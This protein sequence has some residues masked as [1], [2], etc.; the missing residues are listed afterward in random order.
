MYPHFPLP[1]FPPHSHEYLL[2]YVTNNNNNNNNNN[3]KDSP[4]GRGPVLQFLRQEI[5]RQK[6]SSSC[7]ELIPVR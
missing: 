4:H 3:M 6:L 7:E 1:G 5:P 2:I